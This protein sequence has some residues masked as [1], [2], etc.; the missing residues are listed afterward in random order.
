MLHC[1]VASNQ[2]ARSTNISPTRSSMPTWTISLLASR[3]SRRTSIEEEEDDSILSSKK[4]YLFFILRCGLASDSKRISTCLIFD[5][6]HDQQS[7]HPY[8]EN[9]SFFSKTGFD[10]TNSNEP[11]QA[12][13]CVS[14]RERD[15]RSS[16]RNYYYYYYYCHQ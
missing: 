9:V 12:K 1:H 11:H 3:S 14:H 4:T 13:Q 10:K 15:V 2:A 5:A 8:A 6:L 7:H 16:I